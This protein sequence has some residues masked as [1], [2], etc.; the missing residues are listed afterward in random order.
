MGL[1]KD[2]TEKFL[3]WFQDETR[4]SAGRGGHVNLKHAERARITVN[5][6]PC[7]VLYVSTKDSYEL[8]LIFYCFL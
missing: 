2:A 3:H 5:K 7:M 6:I 8:K 1:L 4:Y